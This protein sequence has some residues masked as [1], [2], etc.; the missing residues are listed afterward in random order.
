MVEVVETISV[1]RSV[2]DV[3]AALADYGGIARW[4]P[5]VDHSCVTTR[6]GEGV[7]TTRRVQV[8]RNVLLET[9][10]QWEPGERL[11]YRIE[12]LPPV[13]RS[14][15]TTWHLEAAGSATRITLT[16]TVDTGPRPPQQ[17]VARIVGKALA[18]ACREMLD[19]LRNHLEESAA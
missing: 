9:V 4:A 19:G 16:S 13:V 14:L 8:G 7:G 17:L 18:K 2:G 5:N 11:A 10:V 6:H 12:G 3:W 15:T 1:A